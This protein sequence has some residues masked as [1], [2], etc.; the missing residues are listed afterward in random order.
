MPDDVTSPRPQNDDGSPDGRSVY[1]ALRARIVD[2]ELSPG[3]RLVEGPLAKSFGLSRS[4]IREA[5]GR[6]TYEG[7]L[8]RH[9][10]AMRVRVL[11]PEDVLEL[12]EVRIA[13]E[14]TAARAAAVRRTDLDL[15]RLGGTLDEMRA[16][17]VKD[18]E[19]RPKLAHGFHFVLWRASHNTIL[20]EALESVHLRVTSLSST[21]LHYP[22]RWKVFSEECVGLFGAIRDQDVDR[23]GNIAEQQ[24]TNARD[25]RVKL[26]SSTPELLDRAR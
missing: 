18:K 26:Y 11:K 14:R 3:T 17:K 25:F 9:E 12:Y 10:R 19:R 23:A 20:T 8:E 4:P 24:M 6:L 13:L 2:G 21:T 7:L 16:L 22:E 1:E 15:G 5:L